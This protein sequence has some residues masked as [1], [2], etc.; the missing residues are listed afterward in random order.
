MAQ[1]V[2]ATDA[3]YFPLTDEQQQRPTARGWL[4]CFSTKP[5]TSGRAQRLWKKVNL[6]E[7]ALRQTLVCSASNKSCL[8]HRRALL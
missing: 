3:R 6:Q 4:N 7:S 8:Y 2:D 1:T 5:R